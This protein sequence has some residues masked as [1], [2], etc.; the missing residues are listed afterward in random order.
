[1]RIGRH[2]EVA[3]GT[4]LGG[5]GYAGLYRAVHDQSAMTALNMAWDKGIRA[6]DTAPH[7]GGGLSEERL[8]R[9]LHGRDRA[10][11]TVSTK[12]GRL[13]YDDPAALDGAEGFFGA[14]KRS[15]RRDYSAAGVRRSLEESL[16]RLG[17]DRVDQLLIHD[18]E[19]H[20][21]QALS[22]AVPEAE[23]LRAE[24]LTTGIGVGVNHVGI[25]LRFVR[26]A[27]SITCSSPGGIPCWTAAPRPNCCPNARAAASGCWWPGCSTA[28]CSPIRYGR[29]PS[30]TSPL[31]RR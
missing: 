29:A 25:A 18:P 16:R 12:V 17:L 22:E 6:F 21:V 14:P 2:D 10:R 4:V 5:A 7:Y 26:E 13:L 24:G 8:G 11:Y 23:R 19:D 3:N 30:T 15:R 9:F 28:V 27:R 31:I 1:M 20:M